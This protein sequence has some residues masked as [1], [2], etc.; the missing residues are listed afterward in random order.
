MRSFSTGEHREER[1]SQTEVVFL[2]DGHQV[3]ARPP[4][5]A[6][7]A[8]FQAAYQDIDGDLDQVAD[9]VNFFFAL[10]SGPDFDYFKERLFDPDDSFDLGGDGGMAAIIVN[11]LGV[12][13]KQ[14][15]PPEDVALS[16]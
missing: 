13:L 8:I 7:Y 16:H 14:A 2:H 10:F 3:T 1:I 15:V 12:W 11:L 6:Q 4:T 9:V 5:A